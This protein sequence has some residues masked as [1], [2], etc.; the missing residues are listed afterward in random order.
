MRP[1]D[2]LDAGPVDGALPIPDAQPQDSAPKQVGTFPANFQFGAAT[3]GFQVEMGCPTLAAATCEDQ[4]SDWYQWITTKRILDNS[5]LHMSGDPPKS[6]P[7]FRE[8]WA[9]DLDLAS[10]KGPG[11]LGL[12]TLRLSLEWSRLFPRATFGTT[13]HEDLKNLADQSALRY[14]HDVLSGLKA[15]GMRASVTVTHY[16]LPLWI[17]DGNLCNDGLI[18]GNSLSNCIAAG[19]AGWA[20]PKR[21]RIVNEIAK[22]A[23][24][25]GKEFGADVDEWATMNE[26]FSAVVVAGYLA[27]S[28]TRSNPPGLTGAWLSVSGAKTATMAMIEAH[29]KM[30]DAIKASDTVD[31]D[32]DGDPAKVGIVYSFANISPLTNNAAD[33]EAAKNAD[34]FLHDIFMDGVAFGK[35]D[36]Q[37]DQGPGKG[38]VRP[39]LQNKLDW[40]GVNYYIAFKAQALRVSP[41]PGV[42][43][44]LNFNPLQDFDMDAPGGIFEVLRKAQKYGKPLIVSET[45][46]AFPEEVKRTAWYVRTLSETRRA[47]RSGMDIRG[48]YAWTLMDNYEWNH[49][50][51]LKF[52]LYEVDAQKN[53]K[54]RDSGRAFARM[55]RERDVPANLEA[56][57]LGVFTK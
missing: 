17:H 21:S 51:K 6:G 14:Y 32:G 31:A 57:T 37:W 3:A 7:G 15:R 9:K 40:V 8:L 47:I 48:L 49:G 44:F 26:P 1:R 5:M 16:S 36:E 35:V 39:D 12:S 2:P 38:T 33:A 55:A 29:A 42:S 22:F 19:K 30:Y 24:F 23:G 50:T 53:R 10:G 25:L 28:E 27:A 54:L 56:A 45:G 20:D 34:W 4:N 46:A 18:P 13:S 11:D 41:L 52:G 43:P